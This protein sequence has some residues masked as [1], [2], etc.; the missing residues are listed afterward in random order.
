[1]KIAR[2]L[3]ALATI[4]LT[5]SSMRLEAMA[6]DTYCAQQ[7]VALF[8]IGKGDEEVRLGQVAADQKVQN[9]VA[10]GM[11]SERSKIPPSHFALFTIPKSGSHLI[12]KTLYFLTGFSPEWHMEAPNVIQLYEKQKFPYVHICLPEKLKTF[13][14]ASPTIRQIVGVRDLRDVCVSI[15]FQIRKG[16]WPGFTSNPS[17]IKAF[18]KLSFDAQ[19]M[20]VINYEYDT[21]ENILLQL[22]IAKVANQ[23]KEWLQKP[24]VF[25]CRFEDL[26]GPQGGGNGDVQKETLRKLAAHIGIALT[27]TEVEEVAAHLYGNEE[28]PFGDNEFKNYQSTF[29]EGKIGS[30]KTAFKAQHKKAFKERLGDALIALGY[31]TGNDW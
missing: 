9:L 29:R 7:G 2:I 4:F 23:S 14:Y 8:P 16:T 15:I 10:R 31:E 22:S 28:N 12:L 20:Y 30:W 26:I 11:H 6:A 25:I 5:E 3:I 13:Y 17:K 24:G 21:S 19:L 27:S 1:M 18:K